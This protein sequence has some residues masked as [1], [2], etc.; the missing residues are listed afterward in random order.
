MELC[1]CVELF[2][3]IYGAAPVD[4]NEERRVAAREEETPSARQAHNISSGYFRSN[5]SR[6]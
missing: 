6:D 1:P 3:Y 2:L 4:T 5:I